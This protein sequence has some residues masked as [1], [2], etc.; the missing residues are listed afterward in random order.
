MT[1]RY[2]ELMKVACEATVIRMHEG[3]KADA[4]YRSVLDRVGPA[5]DEEVAKM[6][7]SGEVRRWAT[8]SASSSTPPWA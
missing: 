7:E 2:K 4:W 8:A 5:L 6:I 3:R 1:E